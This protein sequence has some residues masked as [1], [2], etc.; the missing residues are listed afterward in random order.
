MLV[1][2]D[3]VDSIAQ[4]VTQVTLSSKVA[5]SHRPGHSSTQ[6][7]SAVARS[8]LLHFHQGSPLQGL[9]GDLTG[10][11]FEILEIQAGIARGSPSSTRLSNRSGTEGRSGVV[12]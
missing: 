5:V 7:H 10:Q 12:E 3:S 1:F 4:K 11:R 6:L 8:S 9:R 2:N